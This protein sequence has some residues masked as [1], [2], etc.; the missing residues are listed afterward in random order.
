MFRHKTEKTVKLERALL[1]KMIWF[2]RLKKI[3]LKSILSV[4]FKLYCNLLFP[5]EKQTKRQQFISIRKI[6]Q[7]YTKNKEHMWNGIIEEKKQPQK[8]ARTKSK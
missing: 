6:I 4:H 2:R 8:Q 5:I 7:N 1:E 3:S